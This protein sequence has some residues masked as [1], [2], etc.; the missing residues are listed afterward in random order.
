[1]ILLVEDDLQVQ[2]SLR[3][4]MEAAGHEVSSVHDGRQALRQLRQQPAD[5]VITDILMPEVDGLE[6]IRVLRRDFPAIRILAIS[7]G[8]ARLPSADML[9]LARALGADQLLSKPFRQQELLNAICA[10]LKL[11]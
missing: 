1:M 4:A 5:L 7:G 8:A 9:Q 3:I 10:L 2:T 6:L 11:N